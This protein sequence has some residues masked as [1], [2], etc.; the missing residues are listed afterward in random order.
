MGNKN[1]FS[2]DF[3]NAKSNKSIPKDK[4]KVIGHS[5]TEDWLNAF[6][7]ELS[8][9]GYRDDSPYRDRSSIDIHTPTGMI[10]M[11]QTGIPLMANGQYLPPYSGMHNMGTPYVKETPVAK[12]GGWLDNL[13]K[14]QPGYIIKKDKTNTNIENKVRQI[15]QRDKDIRLHNNQTFVGP[16]NRTKELQ[17]LINQD[18]KSEI[19]T[20]NIQKNILYPLDIATDI[21]QLGQFIPHPIAQGIG[22]L[23]N[24]LGAAV[25]ADQA[26]YNYKDKDYNSMVGNLTGV[27]LGSALASQGYKRAI[28]NVTPNTFAQTLANIG[29]PAVS[30]SGF[31]FPLTAQRFGLSKFITNP[32]VKKALNA[33]RGVLAT[34]IGELIYDTSN[35]AY[36]GDISLPKAQLGEFI[37]SWINPYNWG[38]EDYSKYK[39]KGQAFSAARKAGE[40]EFMYNNQRFNTNYAGTPAQQLKETGITNQQLLP[41]NFVRDRISK[42]IKNEYIT[43]DGNILEPVKRVLNAVVNNNSEKGLQ[44]NGLKYYDPSGDDALNLYLGKPQKGNTFGVS[45]YKPTITKTNNTPI[46]YNIQD[47]FFTENLLKEASKHKGSFQMTDDSGI[48]GQFT[49]NRGEDKRGK[50]FSYYD[51]YDLNPYKGRYSNFNFKTEDISMGIGKPYE[52]YDRIY[53]NDNIEIKN[54][55]EKNKIKLDK[56]NKIQKEYYKHLDNTTTPNGMSWEKLNTLSQKNYEDISSIQDEIFSL[57]RKA[58]YNKVYYTNKELSALDSNKKDFDTQALQKELSNRGYK[59]PKSTNKYGTYDGIYGNETKAALLDYQ[60]KNKKAYGGTIDKFGPGGKTDGPIYQGG[61]PFIIRDQEGN[62]SYEPQSDTIY[63]SKDR[64]DK[65]MIHE[66]YHRQQALAGR[67]RIPEYDPYGLARKAPAITEVDADYP[68]FNRRMV[69][70][71]ELTNQFL[72]DNPSFQFADPEAVYN[73]QVNPDMY[74]SFWTAEGEARAAESPEG[75]EYLRSEEIGP[76]YLVPDKKLGGW[77]DTYQGG[78]SY[79]GQDGK[80]YLDPTVYGSSKNPIAAGRPSDQRTPDLDTSW[81]YK[82][83]AKTPEPVVV[84]DPDMTLIP[85]IEARPIKED[86]IEPTPLVRKKAPILRKKTVVV[87]Q[88]AEKPVVRVTAPTQPVVKPTVKPVV[89]PTTPPVSTKPVVKPVTQTK[90]VVPKTNTPAP[91][92]VK[93]QPQSTVKT[94]PKKVTSTINVSEPSILDNIISGLEYAQKESGEILNTVNKNI[95]SIPAIIDRAWIKYGAGDASKDKATEK[96]QNKVVTTVQNTAQNTTQSKNNKINVTPQYK[97]LSRTKEGYISYINVFDNDK[98]FD[99]IPTARLDSESEYNNVAGIAHFLYDYDI[100]KDKALEDEKNSATFVMHKNI[101]YNKDGSVIPSSLK[102]HKANNPGSTVKDPY[103]TTYTKKPDGKVNIKYKKESEITKGDKIADE[104]RQY[105][106]TDIDWNS[107]AQ[108]VGFNSSI[109]TLQTKDKQNTFFIFAKGLGKDAYGKFGGGSVTYLIDGKNLAIDFAGSLTQIK[110][111][112]EQIIKDYKIKPDDLIITYH[113]LGSY[114]AKPG[115]KNGKLNNKTWYDFN[116]NKKTGAGLAIPTKKL[117]GSI[118]WLSKYE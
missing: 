100:T 19:Y 115:S 39:T 4:K 91:T 65:D 67:L 8:M 116:T 54:Q 93:S 5:S 51:T 25:D 55:L 41:N 92:P 77:L 36:G 107:A 81:A 17:D 98:G 7:D 69:D 74:G 9:M 58:N 78:G 94:T 85:R 114:S 38:V 83:S 21:M 79:M 88:P 63:L 70:Q 117:G 111:Q 11:S 50:Y 6:D 10:D 40:K 28:A 57:G 87:E 110:S 1:Q 82:N 105:R 45:K 84:R 2:E 33:N 59:L 104:L 47:D 73:Y 64:G 34:E 26:Y 112:A 86:V 23:G 72:M 75:R 61:G 16:Y 113:D 56:L 46:Y 71:E 68:Y 66:L 109:S 42:N 3:R 80:V 24:T 49:V 95:E 52:V 103:Y 102:N 20:K 35:K 27:G 118:G 62:A 13:P 90:V 43:G 53:Y 18:A 12:N 31:Y 30:K 108:P 106:F 99:Y 32:V 97:E 44:D 48:L 37:P 101:K 89:K 22:W 29:S 60:S 14:A 96:V 15:E 76:D